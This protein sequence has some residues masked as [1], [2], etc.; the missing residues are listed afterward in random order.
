MRHAL[1]AVTAVAITLAPTDHAAGQSYDRYSIVMAHANIDQALRVM[2]EVGWQDCWTDWRPCYNTEWF[3]GEASWHIMI[4]FNVAIASRDAQGRACLLQDAGSTY[5]AALRLMEVGERLRAV[6]GRFFWTY[7]A[8]TISAWLND[9]PCPP[10]PPSTPAWGPSLA[11]SPPVITTPLP[12]PQ[13]PQP[14]PDGDRTAAAVPSGP[15]RCLDDSIPFDASFT[16]YESIYGA[17]PSHLM[18]G[19][20]VCLPDGY[21]RVTRSDMTHYTCNRDFTECDQVDAVTF[22]SVDVEAGQTTY[23]D[24]AGGRRTWWVKVPLD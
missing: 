10:P 2:E 8:A 9:P 13:P 1:V 7:D 6:G 24:R 23:H 4:V 21:L 3:L 15:E 18:K 16:G 12:Q 11:P 14:P 17:G 22:T 5:A 20:F 19:E